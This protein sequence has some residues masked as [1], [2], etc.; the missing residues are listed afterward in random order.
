LLV[1]IYVKCVWLAERVGFIVTFLRGSYLRL[2]HYGPIRTSLC[3][4]VLILSHVSK[5][6]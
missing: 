5:Y 2:E 6:F 4:A 1:L 3:T